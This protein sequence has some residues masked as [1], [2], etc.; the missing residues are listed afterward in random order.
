MRR[1][2]I[3][4]P[5]SGQTWAANFTKCADK[6]SHPHWLSWVGVRTFHYPRDFNRL[7]FR[8]VGRGGEGSCVELA[9]GM[10]GRKG[11]T[12]QAGSGLLGIQQLS[13]LS[14]LLLKAVVMGCIVRGRFD[15]F[16]RRYF[17]KCL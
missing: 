13:E 3:K 8:I 10:T 14:V 17:D 7:V 6:T 9:E 1:A 4:L 16:F 2:G 12:G 5:L 11:R 15:T